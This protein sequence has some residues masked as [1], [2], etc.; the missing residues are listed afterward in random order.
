MNTFSR[1]LLAVL[2]IACIHNNSHAQ[3]GNVAIGPNDPDASAALDVQATNKGVLLPRLTTAERLAIA[4]PAT[5]LMVFDIDEKSF[6]Y[7]EGTKWFRLGVPTDGRAYELLQSDA[8]GVASWDSPTAAS[9]LSAPATEDYNCSKLLGTTSVLN[10]PLGIV[11]SGNYGY[12]ATESGQLK[13][14]DVSSPTAPAIVGEVKLGVHLYDVAVS[15]NHVF[16]P[17]NDL[18][19]LDDYGLLKAIDISD[20]SNP[21][22]IGTV[23]IGYKNARYIKIIGNHAFVETY[24]TFNV[25]DISDPTNM[26]VLSTTFIESESMPF[27]VSGNYAYVVGHGNSDLRIID[28]ST[29]ASP[30]LIA[31]LLVDWRPTSVGVSGTYAYVTTFDRLIHVIDAADPQ[32]AKIVATLNFGKY[33]DVV[34]VFG[35]KAYVSS[36]NSGEIYVFD[37]SDPLSLKQ[38]GT[39]ITGDIP[40]GLAESGGYLYVTSRLGNNVQV[41]QP[42]NC[43]QVLGFDPG[44]GGI[45]AAH[46]YWEA[47]SDRNIYNANGGKVGIGTDAPEK[48]LHLRGS[49]EVELML[50]A[51]GPHGRKW[52]LQSN[53]ATPTVSGI[54]Q[55]IDRTEQQA[56]LAI[57]SLGKVGLGTVTPANQLDVEGGVA[58]GATY[59]G[60]S[61]APANG[62]IIEGRMGIGTSSPEKALHLAGSNDVELMLETTNADGR[63]WVLQSN[64]TGPNHNAQFQIIDRTIGI[65]RLSIDA[66]GS[67]GIGTNAPQAPLHVTGS[68]GSSGGTDIRYFNYSSTNIAGIGNWQGQTAIYAQGNICSTEAFIA[69]QSFNFS[70]ARIKN[71]IGRSDGAADLDRLNQIEITRYTHIDTLAKGKA[72]QTKVIAQQLEQVMPEAVSYTR[73]FIPDVMQVA[74]RIDFR[75]DEKLLTVLLPRPHRLQAGEHIKCLDEKGQEIIVEVLAVPNENSLLFKFDRRPSQLFVYGKRVDDFHIVDYDAIAMLNVSATQELA[76]RLA[77][78]E[79]AAG[80]LRAEVEALKKQ[81]ARLEVMLAGQ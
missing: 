41:I 67:V 70:D 55:I 76:R 65:P 38:V 58:I 25:V 39:I 75:E 32:N 48:A 66:L 79:Q 9:L 20:P 80:Q 5:G 16:A 14:V 69:G 22:V 27:A 28:I 13:I 7:Y 46:T 50:E 11:V 19:D 57:D 43:Q 35:S 72:V 49:S 73:A 29:P 26:T 52:A 6:F 37:I 31:R 10:G 18:I 36:R 68:S 3:T 15:G 30:K 8:S 47:G 33:M 63:K 2:V 60:T 61:A 53:S 77:A 17:V 74:E 59:S 1:Y 56:R 23:D 40:S 62:A 21:I 42:D 54:F 71:I 24:N 81:M 51:N 4:T 44:T 45:Y 34:R 12:I 78:S 64:T